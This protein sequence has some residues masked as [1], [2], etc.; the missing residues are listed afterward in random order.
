MFCCKLI[1]LNSF[2]CLLDKT[3]YQI[4]NQLFVMALLYF[5]C[6][7]LPIQVSLT[8]CFYIYLFYELRISR[9]R[10]N[11]IGGPNRSQCAVVYFVGVVWM[12][13]Q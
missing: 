7:L 3:A 8:S 13:K 2:R 1:L 4:K 11:P 5:F 10:P 9:G 6:S 12:G